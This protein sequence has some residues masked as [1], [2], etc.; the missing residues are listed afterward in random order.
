MS[1][2]EENAAIVDKDKLLEMY[3]TARS[4]SPYS[5]FFVSLNSKDV[6]QRKFRRNFR[7]TDTNLKVACAKM[8]YRKNRSMRESM[9]ARAAGE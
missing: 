3:H 9:H 8:R 1:L 5:F 2:I 6:Y 7:V 4:H